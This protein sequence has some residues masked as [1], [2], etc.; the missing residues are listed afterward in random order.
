MI[1]AFVRY[2]DGVLTPMFP[3]DGEALSMLHSG[4]EYMVSISVP[5]NVK[6]HRKFFALLG[7]CY[8]NMPDYIR[9]R[10]HIHSIDTLLYAIKIAAGHFDN[11]SVN[12]REIPVPRSISFAKMDNAQFERFYNRALD[13]ILETYLVGT[14]RSDIIEEIES[15]FT[16]YR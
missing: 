5:R 3:E 12:G 8:D 16:S 10:D 15:Q 1:K 7:I 6:F 4:R 11:I 13:I 9:K 14:S 2:K